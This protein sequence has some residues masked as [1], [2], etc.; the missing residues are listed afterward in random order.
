M[1]VR[2]LLPIFRKVI[3]N[4][5]LSCLVQF[6]LLK[7]SFENP[8]LSVLIDSYSGAKARQRVRQSVETPDAPTQDWLTNLSQP[9]ILPQ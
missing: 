4:H 9:L 7:G 3:F 1:S 2:R 8:T 6:G 5:L